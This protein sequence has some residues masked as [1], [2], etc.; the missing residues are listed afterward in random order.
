MNARGCACDLWTGTGAVVVGV[1]AMISFC[2][3]FEAPDDLVSREQR[4]RGAH[5][6]AARRTATR[7]QH[8]MDHGTGLIGRGCGTSMTAAAMSL[9]RFDHGPRTPARTSCAS[10][11]W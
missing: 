9:D 10:T 8:A 3:C 7:H 4:E 11:R 2:W 1:L 5:E 6:R